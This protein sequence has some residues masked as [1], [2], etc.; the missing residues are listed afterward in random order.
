LPSDFIP[1]VAPVGKAFVAEGTTIVCHG[2]DSL[3]ELAVPFVLMRTAEG[4]QP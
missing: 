2:G 1:V 4:G 3:E